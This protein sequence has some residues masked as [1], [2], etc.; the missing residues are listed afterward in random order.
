MVSTASIKSFMMSQKSLQLALG[1]F[2]LS[3][4]M[5]LVRAINDSLFTPVATHFSRQL[6]ERIN[7]G[8]IG[9][10]VGADLEA[11]VDAILVFAVAMTAAHV[12]MKMGK[13]SMKSIPLMGSLDI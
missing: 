12:L 9:L 13:V 3:N 2:V 1:F 10:G 8:S 4:V 7:V 6:T 11:V 5:K